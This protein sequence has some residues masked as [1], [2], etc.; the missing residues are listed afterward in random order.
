M[1]QPTPRS[2]SDED[3]CRDFGQLGE[4]P[5]S[6]L[7]MAQFAF[8][9]FDPVETCSKPSMSTRSDDVVTG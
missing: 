3:H 9:R 4:G 6:H 7:A 5:G 2:N 1:R 8:F